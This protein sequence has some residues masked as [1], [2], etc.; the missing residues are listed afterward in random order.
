M[1]YTLAF[2]VYGTLIDTSNVFFS[3]QKL[4][5]DKAAA[6]NESWRNK[7]LEYSFRRSSMQAYV[8]FSVVTK[9]ALDFCC[10][11]H[12][13][14]LSDEQKISLMNE[15]KVLPAFPECIEAITNLKAAGHRLF[16]FSNG[17]NNALFH[18][19]SNAK[20]LNLFEGFVSLED[21]ETFKPNP[22]A[23]AYFNHKSNSTK[24]ESWMISGNPFDVIGAANYGMKTIWV[25]R[26]E[27]NIFDPWE[28]EPT[29]I[30][31]DLTEIKFE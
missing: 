3:L 17:S 28:I 25:K 20:I 27:K 11:K 22:H 14:E 7:Q 19:L 26:S 16:A 8:D 2:D 30:V 12:D 15:Y 21:I 10:S 29:L 5:G 13:V 6:F 1:K 24:E 4:M 18:L 9:Q 31:K 23:Y